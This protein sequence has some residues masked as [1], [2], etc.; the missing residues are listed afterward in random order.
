[1]IRLG[2]ATRF[3]PREIDEFRQV[4]LDM[5]SV[6][7][8]QGIEE[9]LSPWARILANER[10]D[11]LEKLALEMAKSKGV[12]LPPK[13]SAVCG[14]TEKKLSTDQIPFRN[15]GGRHASKGATGREF[16]VI[17]ERFPA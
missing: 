17:A 2:N 5:S 9:E 13:L 7:D 4:G 3:S 6:K 8:Q 14:E 1:M 16:V 11:L 15:F 10:F 12:N